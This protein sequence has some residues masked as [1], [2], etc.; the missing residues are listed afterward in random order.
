M[1]QNGVFYKTPLSIFYLIETFSG[2]N[3]L[4]PFRDLNLPVGLRVGGEGVVVLDS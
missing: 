3:P 1:N 2:P 4:R